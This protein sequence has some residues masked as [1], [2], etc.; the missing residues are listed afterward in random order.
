[1]EP[2]VFEYWKVQN[3]GYTNGV[4]WFDTGGSLV[5]PARF[6]SEKDARK[7]LVANRWGGAEV[8]WRLVH[9]TIA[10]TEDSCVTSE[11]FIPVRRKR[12]KKI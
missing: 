7:Y 5:R 11:R 9:V 12:L 3:T 8:K 1:M 4:S 6:Q 2:E 10:T